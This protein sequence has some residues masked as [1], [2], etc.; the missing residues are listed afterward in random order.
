MR[1]H[2]AYLSLSPKLH[3]LNSASL[4]RAACR[5]T[6]SRRTTRRSRCR[7]RRRR[8][9]WRRRAPRP[10]QSRRMRSRRRT[11]VGAWTALSEAQSRMTGSIGVVVCSW[12]SVAAAM[13]GVLGCSRGQTGF[14]CSDAFVVRGAFLCLCVCACVSCYTG[15]ARLLP[16]PVSACLLHS[17]GWLP[18]AHAR[19][20]S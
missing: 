4:S 2:P 3:S 13:R 1:G 14:G 18:S 20:M 16:M 15:R 17:L 5:R 11:R 7:S 12:H 19:C 8:L 10:R 9:R 6:R